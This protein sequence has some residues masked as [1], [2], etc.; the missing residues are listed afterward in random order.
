MTRQSGPL[1]FQWVAVCLAGAALAA[2]LPDALFRDT[3]GDFHVVWD[4]VGL[5]ITAAAVGTGQWLVLRNGIQDLRWDKWVGSTILG[6]TLGWLAPLIVGWAAVEANNA[7]AVALLG[8]VGG[9]VL[10]FTQWVVLSDYTKRA[11]WWIGANALAG[12]AMFSLVFLGEVPVLTN[13]AAGTLVAGLITGIPLA[14]LL[15]PTAQKAVFGN[16]EPG[17][18]Q[19][20]IEVR[21]QNQG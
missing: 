14:W 4:L 12:A 18:P 21:R 1:W 2:A 7:P 15:D 3:D 13:L 20:I 11:I 9:T 17:R 6:L 16:A 5:L 19:P 8:A 10:G